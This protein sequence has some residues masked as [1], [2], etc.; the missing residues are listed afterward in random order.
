MAIMFFCAAAFAA[1]IVADEL[2][3]IVARHIRRQ[4]RKWYKAS[5]EYRNRQALLRQQGRD[6]LS[7]IMVETDDPWAAP[8]RRERSEQWFRS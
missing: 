3:H 8:A 4:L 1:G 2:G 5:P 7:A 6:K